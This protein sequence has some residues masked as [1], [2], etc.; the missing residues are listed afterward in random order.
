[1]VVN[2]EP[3]YAGRDPIELPAYSIA[4]AARL[5]RLSPSTVRAWTLGQRYVVDG[6][7]KFFRPVI[8][9]EDLEGKTLSFRNL[10]ELHVLAAIRRQ[11]RVSLQ[12]VRRA[13]DFMREK[14]RSD[15]PL[16]SRRMLTD[17]KD[18]LVKHGE[19]LLNV[20]R[21]GQAEMDIVSAFLARIEF[22]RDGALL[23]L[24]PFTSTSID[25]DSR[26]VVIDPRVQFGRPCVRDTGVPTDVIAERFEAGETIESIAA[27]YGI[28]ALAVQ[29]A[30]R[31]ERLPRAA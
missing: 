18:L 24:F 11:Y 1:M 7:T 4:E 29:D 10:V 23:R 26:A 9:V 30:I 31:Y 19:N 8:T 16:A 25:S 5:L 14:L 20:S 17:G 22:A 15:H 13:V 28:D 6:R 27:D 12:N 3:I 2:K 21:A